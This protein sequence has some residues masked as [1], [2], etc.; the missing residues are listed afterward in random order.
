MGFRCEL[1]GGVWDHE[2]DIHRALGG[3]ASGGGVLF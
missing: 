2:E 1:W 3:E